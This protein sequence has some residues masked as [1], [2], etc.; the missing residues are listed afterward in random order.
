[1]MLRFDGEG[2]RFVAEVGTPREL[3]EYLKGRGSY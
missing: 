1:M 2:F 3:S